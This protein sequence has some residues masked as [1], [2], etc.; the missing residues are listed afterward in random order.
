[1]LNFTVEDVYNEVV[2]LADVFQD[3]AYNNQPGRNDEDLCGYAGHTVGTD[4]GQACIVGQALM[5][6]GVPSD[7][8]VWCS[9]PADLLI[10]DLIG[11]P[12]DNMY[13]ILLRGIQ[14]EQDT[15]ET[16]SDAVRLAHENS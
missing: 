12:E 13:S 8:L 10:Y 14:Q 9:L 5:N 15:G 2:R 16:W 11:T 4:D 7:D 6:L 3:F 1:M